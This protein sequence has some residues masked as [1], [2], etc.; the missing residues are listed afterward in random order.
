MRV[1]SIGLPAD[2]RRIVRESLRMAEHML[3][4]YRDPPGMMETVQSWLVNVRQ[5]MVGVYRGYGR[6]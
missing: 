3:R 6:D 5:A 1:P 2:E 4:N